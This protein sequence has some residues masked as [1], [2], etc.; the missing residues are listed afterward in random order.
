MS[1]EQEREQLRQLLTRH[2]DWMERPAH[3]AMVIRIVQRIDDE[4]RNAIGAS[5]NRLAETLPF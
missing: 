4:E 3:R 5:R 2:P 1:I